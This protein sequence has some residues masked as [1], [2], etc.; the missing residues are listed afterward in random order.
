MHE[1]LKLSS[2]SFKSKI[3]GTNSSDFPKLPS[4]VD[5]KTFTLKT[6]E[7][8]KSLSKV[9]FSVSTDET[10]PILT[11]VLFVS[12]DLKS[13]SLQLTGLDFQK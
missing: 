11:G 5:K 3:L 7:F 13:L 12:R 9:L 1:H 2:G 4:I 6:N 8:I 10:R